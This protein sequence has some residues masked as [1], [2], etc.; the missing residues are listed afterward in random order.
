M[1]IFNFVF[2]NEVDSSHTD[3]RHGPKQQVLQLLFTRA[4]FNTAAAA[5]KSRQP[6][7]ILFHKPKRELPFRPAQ[8]PSKGKAME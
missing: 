4:T 2:G 3:W 1:C 7:L 6:A 8:I 5:C